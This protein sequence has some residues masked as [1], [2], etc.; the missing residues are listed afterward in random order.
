MTTSSSDSESPA[1][2]GAVPLHEGNMSPLA[3]ELHRHLDHSERNIEFR[4]AREKCRLPG[5]SATMNIENWEIAKHK[6]ER[7][8]VTRWLDASS[9][10]VRARSVAIISVFCS[11]SADGAEGSS[12]S[13]LA[14]TRA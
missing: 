9:R 11:V 13:R 7:T 3:E 1:Q 5:N 4:P 8:V 6:P 2:E 14:I 12:I 10:S